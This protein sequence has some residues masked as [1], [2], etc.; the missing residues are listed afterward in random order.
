MSSGEISLY[1][2]LLL[3]ETVLADPRPYKKASFAS[4]LLSKVKDYF[5]SKI[6]PAHPE[7]SI[8]RELA[9]GAISMLFSAIGLGKLGLLLG[10]LASTLHIDVL[11]ILTNVY[12]KV[13]ELV[14]SGDKISSG[15][16]DQAVNGVTA[17]HT[18]G[19]TT[20]SLDLMYDAKIISLA[21]IDY[22]R[23]SLRLTKEGTIF[24]SSAPRSA[25]GVSVLGKLLS[26]IIKIALASAGLMVAGDIA[27]KFL[28]R[29][30]SIDKTYDP[31]HPTE[32]AASPSAP[33]GPTSTQTKYKLKGNAPLPTQMPIENNS[34]NISN[35]IIQ[36]AKDTYGG[37]DGKENLIEQTPGFQMIRE[38]I[39][40]YN[41]RHPGSTVTFLPPNW[42]T[43]KQ[44]VDYFIDD[45]AKS[46][47]SGSA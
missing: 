11:G 34:S 1:V 7:A 3:V 44:L 39:E 20:S 6:D 25:Q 30:N 9:P 43:K 32:E 18:G 29:P 17:Q 24:K 13:K 22:E 38:K 45:V 47:T 23:D 27:N 33:S 31:A 26:F 15:Q 8:L 36:F 12:E 35:M 10:F 46:D 42:D 14:S 40:W 37:L 41:A 2:D 16:V 28:G 5:A 4:D 21:L 19:I